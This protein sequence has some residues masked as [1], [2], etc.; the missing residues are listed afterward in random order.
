MRAHTQIYI[1]LFIIVM[2]LSGIGFLYLKK[3]KTYIMSSLPLQVNGHV[4]F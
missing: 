2:Q 4:H 3:I 1:K